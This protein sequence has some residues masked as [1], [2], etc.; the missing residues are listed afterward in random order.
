MTRTTNLMKIIIVRMTRQE[1]NDLR[2]RIDAE[3]Q[4]E[5]IVDDSVV[6]TRT[7]RDT[8]KS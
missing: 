2:N 6:F 8:F 1:C 3:W 7:R 5:S 4:V